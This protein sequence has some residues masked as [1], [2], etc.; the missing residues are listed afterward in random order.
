[1]EAHTHTSKNWYDKSYKL[2][3]VV[4]LIVLAICIF[5][6][7]QFRA[8]HGDW[9]L[10]DTSLSGGTTVTLHGNI[11]RQAL[12]T[13]LKPSFPDIYIRS[14]TELRTG[15]S[16]AIIIETSAQPQE[17]KASLESFLGRALKQDEATIEFTGP[18]LSTTF[19]KQLMRSLGFSFVL[20]CI[21]VFVLFRTVVPSMA[22]IFAIIADI[23]MSLTAINLLGV[24]VSAA[25]IA[26]F[27]ML[28]GYSVDT[29]ILL[30]S[31]VLKRRE[32][33]VNQRIYGAFVT[34]IFMTITAL[35]AV[36][37]AFFIVTGLPDSFRQIFLILGIGLGADII[38]T[39]MTNASMIK[40]YADSK[41][42]K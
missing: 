19:S 30:T 26:A 3:L 22:V 33:S 29:D 15:E 4:P 41:G 5:Y 18:T 36:L 17:V 42:M 2:L 28:I 20:I 8:D 40:W 1:M 23:L 32:G 31:R 9:I 11:D 14:I 35:L 24:H 34:G 13:A 39:W 6:L 12:E 27:L 38:N 21:V 16:L 25:G 37:P 7:F 10:K